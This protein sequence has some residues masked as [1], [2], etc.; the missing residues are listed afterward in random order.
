MV[1]RRDLIRH[2][3]RHRCASSARARSMRSGA[4][5]AGARPCRA[6]GRSR[7]ARLVRSAVSSGSR[8]RRAASLCC[9]EVPESF[10]IAQVA[11]RALE[12]ASDVGTFADEVSRELAERGHRVLLLAPSRSPELVRESRKLIRAAR[13]KPEALFDPDGGVRVLGV[14]ELLPVHRRGVAPSPP[15]DIARTIEDVLTIAKLDFVHVHEPWA[16]SA[17]SV[18]LRHSRALNV[19]SF[20]APAERV[21]STQVARKFV[22][23]FFGRMDARTAS[24]EATGEL[25]NRYFPAS[26]RLLRPGI[27]P[28]PR[29]STGGT[30]RSRSPTARSAARCGSSCGR[31]ARFPRSC[32]GRRSSTRRRAR[33]P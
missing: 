19:G 25:L 6:I 9:G 12:E 1:K 23:L 28:E 24:Y 21:L 30:I 15:V 13:E 27:T 26:Y 20:H 8:R 33:P 11:P 7:S 17:G 3:E 18:A 22:E 31:C 29:A 16:P 32:R 2:L 5:R 4:A 10:A 14:G